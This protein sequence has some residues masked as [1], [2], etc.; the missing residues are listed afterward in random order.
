MPQRIIYP[1]GSGGIVVLIPS[2]NCGLTIGQIAKKDVP[3]GLP[4]RIVA[5]E[6]IPDDRVFRGAWVCDFSTFDGYGGCN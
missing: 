3:N 2:N 4:Y 5:T 6:D 1:N